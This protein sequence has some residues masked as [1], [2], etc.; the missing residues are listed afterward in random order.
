MDTTTVRKQLQEVDARLARIDAEREVL[1]SLRTGYN[2]WLALYDDNQS[3][4]PPLMPNVSPSTRKSNHKRGSISV[5]GA[6]LKVMQNAPGV[7]LH[8]E[9]IW[10]RAEILGARTSSPHPKD[11]V[12]LNLFGLRKQHPIEK[13]E[14][15]TYMWKNGVTVHT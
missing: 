3:A 9:E 7:A 1:L 5:R 13:V 14:A 2:G 12:D 8:S 4:Q 10:R 6:I 15:R 11:V